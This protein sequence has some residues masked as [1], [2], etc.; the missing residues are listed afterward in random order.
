MAIVTGFIDLASREGSQ[1][2]QRETYKQH[3]LRLFETPLPMIIFA[4]PDLVDW[5]KEHRKG[6]TVIKEFSLEDSKYYHYLEELNQ[7]YRQGKRS[8]R[9]NPVKDTPNYLLTTWTKMHWME[10]ALEYDYEFLIWVDFGIGHACPFP[11]DWSKIS[12]RVPDT[13]I[14]I[15]GDEV[16]PVNRLDD[17]PKFYREQEA[18][19]YSPVTAKLMLGKSQSWREL[20]NKFSQDLSLTRQLHIPAHEEDILGM[21]R[22]RYP[23]LIQCFW[24]RDW[25]LFRLLEEGALSYR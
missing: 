20:V 6:P 21:V 5:V 3:A 14:L 9:Y 10:I 2:R 17:V 19:Y 23:R 11:A 25:I 8:P 24:Y 13:G 18:N 7:E 4:E 16:I 15:P 22:S 12:G 1:R